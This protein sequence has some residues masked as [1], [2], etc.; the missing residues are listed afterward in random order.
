MISSSEGNLHT[1]KKTQK[2]NRTIAS[3]K[4]K[5]VM[6]L[7]SKFCSTKTVMA[8]RLDIFPLTEKKKN[9]GSEKEI[10]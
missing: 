7:E 5:Q 4:T 8:L 1:K 10:I 3:R 6:T 2:T 9:I